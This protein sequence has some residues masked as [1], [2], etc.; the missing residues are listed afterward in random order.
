MISP[1]TDLNPL[2]ER[3]PIHIR[4]WQWVLAPIIGPLIRRRLKARYDA[5][6]GR[7]ESLI[8]SVREC[9]TR[10]SLESLLGPPRYAM[11]GYLY[12]TVSADGSIITHADTVEVYEKDGCAIELWFKDGKMSSM[13]GTAA[14][15]TS[16]DIVTGAIN[17]NAT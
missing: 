9:K 5:R 13:I 7:V 4:R 11:D 1:R 17:G 16:W 10:E 12:S 14:C 15:P 2:S 6:M 3:P 8:A